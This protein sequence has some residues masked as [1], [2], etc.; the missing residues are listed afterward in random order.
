MQKRAHQTEA[1]N[2][3]DVALVFNAVCIPSRAARQAL[4]QQEPSTQTER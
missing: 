1:S 2:H 4:H 3:R